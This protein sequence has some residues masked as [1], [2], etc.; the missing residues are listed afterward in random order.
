MAEP[1]VRDAKSGLL[2]PASVVQSKQ[3]AE[4]TVPSKKPLPKERIASISPETLEKA[5]AAAALV[6]DVVSNEEGML[7]LMVQLPIQ[8]L[9]ELYLNNI[10]PQISVNICNTD[11]QQMVRALGEIKKNRAIRAGMKKEV[12]EMKSYEYA[13][14]D[15][16][17]LISQIPCPA[18]KFNLS[19]PEP[20]HARKEESKKTEPPSFEIPTSTGNGGIKGST[21]SKEPEKS[22]EKPDK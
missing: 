13:I 5:E 19:P 14:A 6:E 7:A 1:H 22:A 2:I 16:R 11:R 9:M 17:A 21:E 15:L 8:D 4:N 12:I 3:E 18:M 10:M 20:V